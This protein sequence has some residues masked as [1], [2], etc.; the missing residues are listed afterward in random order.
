MA[1]DDDSSAVVHLHGHRRRSRG[2]AL[3]AA[4]AAAT[5]E[6]HVGPAV[7]VSLPRCVCGQSKAFPMCDGSHHAEAWAPSAAEPVKFAIAA[8]PRYSNMALKLASHFGV[9]AI[10]SAALA[11]REVDTLAV[12]A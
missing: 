3:Q 1:D 4:A 7:A 8:G 10:V 11:P 6:S 5:A 9:S 12:R 2:W